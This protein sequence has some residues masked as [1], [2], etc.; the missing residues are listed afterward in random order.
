MPVRPEL[1]AAQRALAALD[2]AHARAASELDRAITHRAEI[3]SEQDR[4]VAAVRARVD[5]A[6]AEMAH[7]VSVE[8][9]ARL[10]GLSVNRVKRLAK[11]HAPAS[12]GPTAALRT[13][14]ASA[15]DTAS[16]V[17]PG[18]VPRSTGDRALI[19]SEACCGSVICFWVR[20]FCCH[21]RRRQRRCSGLGSEPS[22]RGGGRA[23]PSV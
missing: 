2:A 23:H 7:Q 16:V 15:D 4:H 3:V 18:S 11:A 22:L 1:F 21:N 19:V 6:V 13:M 5:R 12:A 20:C 17:R 14:R 8:L 9:T 10:L